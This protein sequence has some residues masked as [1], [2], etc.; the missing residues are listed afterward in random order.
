VDQARPGLFKFQGVALYYLRPYRGMK[1][2]KSTILIRHVL[3]GEHPKRFPN[4]VEEAHR[5]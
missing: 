2:Q 3:R 1:N 4:I 5:E